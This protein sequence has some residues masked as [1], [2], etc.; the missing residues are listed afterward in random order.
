M[1]S[2]NTRKSEGATLPLVTFFQFMEDL[3]DLQAMDAMRTRID[4]KY[5]LHLPVNTLA[6]HQSS[7]CQFRQKVMGDRVSQQEFQILVD[8]LVALHPPSNHTQ[9]VFEILSFLSHICLINIKNHAIEAMGAALGALASRYP[10][11]LLQVA[12]PHWYWRF[13]RLSST[14]PASSL[15]QQELSMAKLG[16]DIQHLLE[17]VQRSTL[18]NIEHMQEIKTLRFIWEQHFKDQGLGQPPDRGVIMQTNCD[19]CSYYAS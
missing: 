15:R 13:N 16:A 5:A 11:W 6:F 2:M 4:W 7:L 3:T 8:R 1:T 9:Q 14:N 10:D 19:S 17:E 12:Q 18:P